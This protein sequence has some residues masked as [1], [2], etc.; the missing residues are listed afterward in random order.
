M[1]LVLNIF[2]KSENV[3]N[4]FY[5]VSDARYSRINT[6]EQL[7]ADLVDKGISEASLCDETEV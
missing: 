1:T 3:L 2:K 5:C 6:L 4:L 7:P